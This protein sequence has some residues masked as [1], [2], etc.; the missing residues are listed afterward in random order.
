MKTLSEFRK[1]KKA[2]LEK[3][4]EAVQGLNKK[5]VDENA[6]KFWYPKLDKQGSGYAKIRFLP[7][8]PSEDVNFIRMYSYSFQD[9]NTNQWFIDNCPTTIGHPSPVL[10]FNNAL[11]GG[12]KEFD[13]SPEHVQARRQK[14]KLHYF[15]NVYI[16]EDP[17]NEENQGKVKL[18]KLGKKLFDKLNGA[19]FP[20]TLFPPTYKGKIPEP[21]NP[22]D[23][24]DGADFNLT[25]IRKDG[26]TNYD[27]SNFEDPTPFM[28]GNA[29]KIETIW[30]QCHLL[31]PFLAESN[32]KSYE[33]LERKLFKVLGLDK[34]E[35]QARKEVMED[36]EEKTPVR[37]REVEVKSTAS[38]VLPDEDED[39]DDDDANFLKTLQNRK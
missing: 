13:G 31:Q 30:N 10:D 19:M 36:V 7:A 3:A 6:D 38:V 27:V 15:V 24:D 32:F 18:F 16:I 21:M 12:K 2:N 39:E 11:W 8:H 28:E 4:R 33:E 9:P 29:K 20:E 25:I 23:F 35:R 17:A 1:N 34:V 22:Y 37:H 14:R 5:F 26:N